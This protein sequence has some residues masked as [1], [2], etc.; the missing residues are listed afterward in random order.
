MFNLGVL[1]KEPDSEAVRR[2][3]ERPVG[4]YLPISGQGRRRLSE[5]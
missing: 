5:M 3:Y 1:L 2:C 4:S